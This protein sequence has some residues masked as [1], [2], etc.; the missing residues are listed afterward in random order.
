MSLALFPTEAAPIGLL[1]G[2]TALRHL[3]P[4]PENMGRLVQP[5]HRRSSG[6]GTRLRMR[7]NGMIWLEIIS[8][9][10]AGII[11]AGKVCEIC[12]QM[13]QFIADEKLLKLTVFC[14]AKYST[15]ISIHLQWKYEYGSWSILGKEIASAL[16]DLGLVSHTLWIEHEEMIAYGGALETNSSKMAT[17]MKKR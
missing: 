9:R 13:L 10:T 7:K 16:G 1:H 11:E 3:P 17:K 6:A 2:A 5:H 4:S 12:R 15:D 8:I 14:N